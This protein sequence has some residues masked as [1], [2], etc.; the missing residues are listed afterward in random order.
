LSVG[1]PD[2]ASTD[3]SEYSKYHR[4]LHADDLKQHRSIANLKVSIDGRETAHKY[5]RSDTEDLYP[6]G[7]FIWNMHFNP[8]SEHVV[9]VEYDSTLGE[10]DAEQGLDD[11]QAVFHYW[12]RTGAPWKGRIEEAVVRVK[13]LGT[14]RNSIWSLHPAGASWQDDTIT[15]RFENIEPTRAHDIRIGCGGSNLRSE[16]T[17]SPQEIG[18]ILQD[19]THEQWAR[20]ASRARSLGTVELLSALVEA[21]KKQHAA[22]SS[23]TDEQ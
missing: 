23:D 21:A 4:D 16:P 18:T 20:A 10:E 2:V 14:A 5:E 6:L 22:E 7:W 13:L 19:P 9:V 3:P 15:W 17:L 12:L 11:V 1:F 8:R